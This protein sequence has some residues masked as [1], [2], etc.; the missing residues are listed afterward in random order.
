RKRRR[1]HSGIE[2]RPRARGSRSP[3]QSSQDEIDISKLADSIKKQWGVKKKEVDHDDKEAPKKTGEG[4][5][6]AEEESEMEHEDSE[7]YHLQLSVKFQEE[8]KHQS[9]S[10][11]SVPKAWAKA[12]SDAR[13]A[14]AG[15]TASGSTP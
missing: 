8:A 5:I 11:A 3:L 6:S 13:D 15:I 12:A 4:T 2:A 1:G 9:M 7:K 10:E 14:A